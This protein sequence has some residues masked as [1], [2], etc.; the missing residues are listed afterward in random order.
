MLHSE[1]VLFRAVKFP[2]GVDRRG[3]GMD[4]IGV[5]ASWIPLFVFK[6]VYEGFPLLGAREGR[7]PKGGFSG[8]LS[9]QKS[10]GGDETLRVFFSVSWRAPSL[11][12]V[13]SRVGG[14]YWLYSR[15]R[16]ERSK[17]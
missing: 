12:F 14:L 9:R 1:S 17:N 2:R 11:R 3:F 15:A 6:S 7:P 5:L 4:V 8:P 16:V 10:G 13:D